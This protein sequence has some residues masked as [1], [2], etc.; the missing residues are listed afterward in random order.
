MGRIKSKPLILSS[1]CVLF[2][3]TLHLSRWGLETKNGASIIKGTITAEASVS[4]FSPTLT[5]YESTKPKPS[6]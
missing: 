5:F 2:S 3:V 4:Y 6:I 1:S